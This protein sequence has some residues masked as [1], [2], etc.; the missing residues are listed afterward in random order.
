MPAL[1]HSNGCWS[2]PLHCSLDTLHPGSPGLFTL[3]ALNLDRHNNRLNKLFISVD[4]LRGAGVLMLDA[5][6]NSH[7]FSL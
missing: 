5:S 1:P 3:I 6:L 4:G 7:T 2:F